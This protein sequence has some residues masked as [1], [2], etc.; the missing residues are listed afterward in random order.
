MFSFVVQSKKRF[1]GLLPF[2]GAYTPLWILLWA[3]VGPALGPWW[4]L[5]WAL[6][7][8]ALVPLWALPWACVGPALGPL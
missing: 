8:P 1:P 6:V 3:L 7:G 4:A 5:P 2:V